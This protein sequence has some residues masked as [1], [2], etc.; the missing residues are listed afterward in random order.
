MTPMVM[1]TSSGLPACIPGSEF[2]L[3]RR[4][5][6]VPQGLDSDLA[7]HSFEWYAHRNHGGFRQLHHTLHDSDRDKIWRLSTALYPEWRGSDQQRRLLI[8]SPDPRFVP[9]LLATEE[10]VT[11][12]SRVL[13]A[14]H[15]PCRA[16]L[17][18]PRLPRKAPAGQGLPYGNVSAIPDPCGLQAFLFVLSIAIR[19]G[20]F[21]GVKIAI[22]PAGCGGQATER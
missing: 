19:I 16:D 10:G 2:R 14:G 4:F 21:F 7:V 17:G 6:A 1:P 13:S 22:G 8:P 18:L 9:L 11:K 15:I 5:G 20:K 12:P 3:R